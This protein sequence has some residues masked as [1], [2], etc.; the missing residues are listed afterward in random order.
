MNKVKVD[1]KPEYIYCSMQSDGK[2]ISHVKVNYSGKEWEISSWFTD[3]GYQNKGIGT[4]LLKTAMTSLVQINGDPE[5]VTYTWNGTNSYV[6]VWLKSK[7]NAK[8]NCPLSVLKYFNG[9]L[10]DAHIYTLDTERVKAF[11]KEV[12]NNG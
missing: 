10:W 3:E 2:E 1:L 5:K 9:D 7:F 11:L 4:T 8:C 12:G 6:L